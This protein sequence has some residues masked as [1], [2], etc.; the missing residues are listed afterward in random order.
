MATRVTVKLLSLGSGE[1]LG[2]CCQ[3]PRATVSL[4]SSTTEGQ[5][6]D[7]SPSSLEIIVLLPNCFKSPKHV[8][9]TPMLVMDV[10]CHV[11]SQKCFVDRSTVFFSVSRLPKSCQIIMQ[12][13]NMRDIYL[14][15]AL[16]N[17]TICRLKLHMVV[18]G[19]NSLRFCHRS[20]GR[21]GFEKKYF[22]LYC[23]LQ[24]SS[25]ENWSALSTNIV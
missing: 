11:T 16:C 10:I 24:S 19:T 3:R 12:H 9:S 6:F 23:V 5:W 13:S 8:N 7:C 17:K 1:D 4:I 25:N 2:N 18:I 20:D 21:H 22:K 14:N 15:R